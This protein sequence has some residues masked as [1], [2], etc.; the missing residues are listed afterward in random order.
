[1]TRILALDLATTTGWACGKPTGELSH[2][3]I[4]FAKPGAS[5]EAIFAAACRWMIEMMEMQP[6]MVVFEA[7]MATSFKKGK[8]NASTTA[9]LYGLPAVV[10]AVAFMSG[11]YNIRKAETRDVRIHFIGSNLPRAKAKAL[12]V[13][14][15][16]LMGW[17]VTDDNEAD[18]LATWHYVCTLLGDKKCRW[19]GPTRSPSPRSSPS[20]PSSIG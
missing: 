2:G 7:P 20:S 6:D 1:M 17:D 19:A 10:G 18:A 12:T 8:T 11:C 13:R 3:F 16:R 9:L 5:H 15:C 4:R 14:N